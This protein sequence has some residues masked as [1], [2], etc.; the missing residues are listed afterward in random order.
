VTPEDNCDVEDDKGQV[1]TS[2]KIALQ[3]SHNT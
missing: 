3:M 1:S 2:V